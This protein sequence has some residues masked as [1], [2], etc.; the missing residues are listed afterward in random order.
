MVG[1]F[2]SGEFINRFRAGSLV[3]KTRESSAGGVTRGTS[4]ASSQTAVRNTTLFG[5]VNGVIGVI[6]QL[7]K[8]DFAFALAVEAAMN[9]GTA[10]RVSQIPPPYFKP[11]S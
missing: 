1:E 10:L 9:K 7:T 3:A 2:H 8:H 6:A 11:R 5:T 4:D